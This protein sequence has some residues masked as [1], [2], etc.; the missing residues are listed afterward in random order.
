MERSRHFYNCSGWHKK[1]RCSSKTHHSRDDHGYRLNEVDCLP[2]KDEFTTIQLPVEVWVAWN[3]LPK[4]KG[5]Q[6]KRPN[7]IERGFGLHLTQTP[8][9]TFQD[10]PRRRR[11]IGSSIGG[12]FSGSTNT[13]EV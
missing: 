1:E 9:K 2:M 13:V 10:A 11:G 6:S 3:D 5:S 7:I 12:R 4:R 8:T